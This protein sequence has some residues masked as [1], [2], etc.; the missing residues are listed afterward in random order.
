MRLDINTLAL[1]T[2]PLLPRH[3]DILIGAIFQVTASYMSYRNL[4]HIRYS[5][6]FGESTLLCRFSWFLLNTLHHEV[7]EY[8]WITVAILG[9]VVDTISDTISR[10]VTIWLPNRENRA[11]SNA[12]ADVFLSRVSVRFS[13]YYSNSIAR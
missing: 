4:L 9:R 11:I 6:S 12:K 10:V 7:S 2:T 5:Q 1:A 3:I 8:S 13:T